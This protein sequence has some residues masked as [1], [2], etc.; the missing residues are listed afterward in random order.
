MTRAVRDGMLPPM[1]LKSSCCAKYERKAKA[2][3]GCPVMALWSKKK[4]R[5]ELEKVRRRLKKAA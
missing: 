5:K 4:R 1:K 3:K 2:C